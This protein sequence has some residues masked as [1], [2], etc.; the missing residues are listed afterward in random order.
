MCGR[1]SIAYSAQKE[2]KIMSES[3]YAAQK[4]HLQSKKQLRVWMDAEKYESFKTAVQKDGK[5]IYELINNFV[6][7]YLKEKAGEWFPGF[8]LQLPP[9][10]N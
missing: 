1:Y 2:V 5:S 4:K 9:L 7:E 10:L 8:L 3:N 6:D